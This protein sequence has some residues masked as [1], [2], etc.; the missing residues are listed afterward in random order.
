MSEE[1]DPEGY[2]IQEVMT[3]PVSLD[4]QGTLMYAAYMLDE[5]G[6]RADYTFYNT[7]EEAI[8]VCRKHAEKIRNE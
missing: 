8:A 7:R 2:K 6:L 4:D 3:N 5:S 1:K